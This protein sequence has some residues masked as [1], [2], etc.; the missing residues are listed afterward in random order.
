MNVQRLIEEL[1]QI[2]DKTLP[3]YGYNGEI[4]E[5]DFVDDTITDRVDLN[6]VCD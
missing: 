3:V 1:E 4:M 6:L 5:V 2:E